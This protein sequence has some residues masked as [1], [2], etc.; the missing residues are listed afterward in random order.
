MTGLRRLE[1][2]REL[3]KKNKGWIHTHLFRLLNKQD[4]WNLAYRNLNNNKKL[5]FSVDKDISKQL[6]QLQQDVISERYN[7]SSVQKTTLLNK[8]RQQIF[9]ILNDNIVQEVIRIILEAVYSPIL[10]QHSY[11]FETNRYPHDALK[12]IE[13]SFVSTKWVIQGNIENFYSSINHCSLCIIISK[14]IAD[15]RMIRLIQ[16]CLRQ[17][18]LNEIILSPRN[19]NISLNT[20]IGPILANIYYNE[21]DL[22]INEYKEKLP[23]VFNNFYIRNWKNIIS[24]D[25]SLDQDVIKYNL[26]YV[27]Y[28][29]NWMI[30]INGKKDIAV[31]LKLNILKFISDNLKYKFNPN[32]IQ[33]KNLYRG[34]LQFLGYEIFILNSLT[35]NNKNKRVSKSNIRFELPIHNFS[36]CLL[37]MGLICKTHK[38]IRPISNT[39]LIS[40]K[41]E[42]IGLYYSQLY[43]NIQ[44]Y[45]SG[46]TSIKQLRYIHYLL[47]YS[48][49][50]TLAHKHRKSISQIFAIY[51]KTLKINR[52]N[53]YN[54][55]EFPQYYVAIEKKG[56]WQV[57]T[58]FNDPIVLHIILFLDQDQ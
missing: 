47:K 1:V 24:E 28:K 55:L 6:Y 54:T 49:A 52:I 51:G 13:S 18:F 4:I 40:Q 17:G 9:P 23:E 38:G 20:I 31:Y 27:R 45:Y 11:A 29:D 48:Y 53:S 2:I 41:D 58:L 30:G 44:N 3:S 33:I 22:N 56:Q 43:L 12:Y 39:N 10:Y 46:I 42:L 8:H 32:K 35:A 26:Y 50:M 21:L 5:T 19:I 7:F 14:R 57:S 34:S 16:K 36:R 25:S 15:P 37:K